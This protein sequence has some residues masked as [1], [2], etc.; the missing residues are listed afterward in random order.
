MKS[1]EIETLALGKHTMSRCFIS[2]REVG[3]KMERTRVRTYNEPTFYKP[4][5]SWLE[6]GENESENAL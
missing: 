2:R 5:R 1:R 4:P 3:W 6:N